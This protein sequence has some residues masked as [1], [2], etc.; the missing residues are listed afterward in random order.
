MS[1]VGWNKERRRE[2]ERKKGKEQWSSSVFG[3]PVIGLRRERRDGM[4]IMD[5]NHVSAL[6]PEYLDRH[7]QSDGEGGRRCMLE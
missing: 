7:S 5:A 3:R 2:E 1:K 4:E 6:C